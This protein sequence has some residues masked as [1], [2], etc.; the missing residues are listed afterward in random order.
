MTLLSIMAKKESLF[1]KRTG[2]MA[3]KFNTKA[4]FFVATVL[5]A[6][7]HYAFAFMHFLFECALW[8]FRRRQFRRNMQRLGESLQ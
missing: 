5:I 3:E 7:W 6:L 8:A 2:K 4:E 1:W